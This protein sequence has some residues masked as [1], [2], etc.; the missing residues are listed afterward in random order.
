MKAFWTIYCEV[1]F[2]FFFFFWWDNDIFLFFHLAY[3][4]KYAF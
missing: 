3:I 4:Q 1:V 2:F